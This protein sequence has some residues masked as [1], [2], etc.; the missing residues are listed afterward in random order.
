LTGLMATDA[1]FQL[2]SYAV[3]GVLAA[4]VYKS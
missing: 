3:S 1:I 4:V 2:A